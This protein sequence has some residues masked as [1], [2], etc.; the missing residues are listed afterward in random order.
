MHRDTRRTHRVRFMSHREPNCPRHAACPSIAAAVQQASHASERISQ[1]DARRDRI[2]Y[3]P[4]LQLFQPGIKHYSEGCADES[5]VKNQTAVLDHENFR[6]RLVGKLLPPERK[7]VQAS[8]AHN[9]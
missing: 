8:T 4:D 7:D 5:A 3:F 9:A 6:E 2:E 1:R